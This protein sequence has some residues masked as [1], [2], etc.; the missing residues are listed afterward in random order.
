LSSIE[1]WRNL[2]LIVRAEPPAEPTLVTAL[3]L[4]GLGDPDW[5]VRMTAMI[6]G[7]RLGIAALIDRI[8][9][10]EVPHA[11][12]NSGLEGE[13]RRVLLAMRQAAADCLRGASVDPESALPGDDDVPALRRACQLH[14][15]RLVANLPEPSDRA[16]LLLAALLTPETLSAPD[17]FPNRW[18]SWLS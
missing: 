6:G 11:G 5:R 8:A 2:R 14:L 18:K 13:D 7:A 9:A 1:R 4:A 3:L 12:E 16:T 10:V 15:R 17:S